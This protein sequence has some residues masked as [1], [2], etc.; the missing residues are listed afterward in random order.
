MWRLEKKFWRERGN[1]TPPP[2][3]APHIWPIAVWSGC[4]GWECRFQKVRE[5]VGCRRRWRGVRRGSFLSSDRHLSWKIP[6]PH[7]WTPGAEKVAFSHHLSGGYVN[8][9]LFA[10][11]FM[12]SLL[13]TPTLWQKVELETG[14]TEKK[15]TDSKTKTCQSKTTWRKWIRRLFLRNNSKNKTY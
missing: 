4:E 5:N 15:T 8:H 2:F 3:S 10:L 6:T 9:S 13:F 7:R 1:Q 12:K 14:D 11:P